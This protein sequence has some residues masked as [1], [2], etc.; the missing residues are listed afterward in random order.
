MLHRAPSFITRSFLRSVWASEFEAYVAR[1]EDASC[2]DALRNW[3]S[4]IARGEVAD[5]GALIATLFTHLWGYRDVGTQA[6]PVH[7]IY[8][9]F[10]VA[11]AGPRGRGGAV[12]AALGWWDLDGVP[13]AMQV[14]CEFK[15]LDTD[16]DAPQRGR[17]DNRTP[18]EQALNYLGCAR[19]GMVGNEDVKPTWAIV[20]DMNVFRLYWYDRA[21]AQYLS[22]NIEQRSLY[23]DAA[24]LSNDDESRFERYLF[25]RLFHADTLLTKAGKPLLEHLARLIHRRVVFGLAD[26][27]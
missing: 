7:S 21:P 17:P 19:R 2:L 20:T 16:L 27:A 8:P 10:P 23:Q 9:Q 1:G 26:V 3:S 5:G 24:L 11:G 22:F 6:E 18:V 12:D 14:A 13:S 4:R 15:P 25:K